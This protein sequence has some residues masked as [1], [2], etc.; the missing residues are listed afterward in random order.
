M[1]GWPQ[2][3][4]CKNCIYFNIQPAECR[5][6]PPLPQR[7]FPMVRESD[8]CSKFQSEEEYKKLNAPPDWSFLE[9]GRISKPL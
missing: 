4:T 1:P 3:K 8:W 6:N 9:E 7:Q 2:E 5:K